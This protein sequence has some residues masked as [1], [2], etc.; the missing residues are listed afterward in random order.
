M[1]SPAQRPKKKNKALP[2]QDPFLDA[3]VA[4]KC[5]C[6]VFQVNGIRLSGVIASYD[7]Y[8]LLLAADGRAPMPVYKHGVSTI[9]P[10]KG[11]Q[12]QVKES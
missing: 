2:V 9:L 8:T 10:P 11:F 12:F 1:N 7:E 3:L 5:V 4:S 6:D